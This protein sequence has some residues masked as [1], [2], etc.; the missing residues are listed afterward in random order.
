MILVSFASGIPQIEIVFVFM[1]IGYTHQ[2]LAKLK[3][4]TEMK[5]NVQLITDPKMFLFIS[6]NSVNKLL[7]FLLNFLCV[8]VATESQI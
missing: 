4:N 5:R 7:K 3:H 6:L 1:N 2:I 8:N